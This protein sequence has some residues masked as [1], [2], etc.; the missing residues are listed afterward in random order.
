MRFLAQTHIAH[1][2]I[3]VVVFN[4]K[5]VSTQKVCVRNQCFGYPLHPP[6]K[7]LGGGKLY[8]ETKRKVAESRNWICIIFTM[9]PV[10]GETWTHG[11]ELPKNFYKPPRN[12][13]GF[14]RYSWSSYGPSRW[15]ESNGS[16]GWK[17]VQK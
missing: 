7:F 14:E 6:P 12:R 10:L 8:L 1:G 2:L 13:P 9:G 16:G 4:L 3:R 15:V 5:K 11:K 17:R